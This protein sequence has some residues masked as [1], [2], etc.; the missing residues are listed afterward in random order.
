MKLIVT[1]GNDNGQYE[2]QVFDVPEPITYLGVEV[3]NTKTP[4]GRAT[5]MRMPFHDHGLGIHSICSLD[6][7]TVQQVSTDDDLRRA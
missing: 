1:V 3:E 2:E 6:T 5:I 4:T 7:N